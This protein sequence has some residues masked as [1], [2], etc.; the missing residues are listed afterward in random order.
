MNAKRLIV[1]LVFATILIGFFIWIIGVFIDDAGRKNRI[2]REQSQQVYDAVDYINAQQFDIMYYGDALKAPESLTVRRIPNLDTTSIKSVDALPD[3]KA[4]LIII[5]DPTGTAGL[6]VDDWKE[7]LV[8]LKHENCSI[9]Y[10]GTAE[11]PDMQEAG[12]FFDVYPAG[13]ASIIFWKNGTEYEVGFA[14][15]YTLIPEVV[16]E[17]LTDAQLPVYGMIMKLGSGDYLKIEAPQPKESDEDPDDSSAKAP[18]PDD[19][20]SEE[21]EEKK[22]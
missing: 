12:Y 13:T 1:T 4:R 2:W 16:R 21:S 22:S 8:R 7:L 17:T 14:D 19:S 20:S 18:A 5:N 11:L 10:L 15:D 6:T 9:I 3:F